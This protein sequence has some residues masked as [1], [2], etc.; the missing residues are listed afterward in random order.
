MAHVIED[1]NDLIL[2]VINMFPDFRMRLKL[3]KKTGKVM[4]G[5]DVQS[6]FDICWYTFS[7]IVAD[8]APPVDPDLRYEE[9]QGAILSCLC[10]GEFFV[11]HSS[12]QLY[13]DNPNC[14][15]ER[16][17]KNRRANYARKKAAE[18]ENQG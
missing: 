2:K 6:V 18:A 9:S 1:Y 12:R 11:R 15:A 17:R 8:V 5:A 4:F 16:N 13:C 10:C 7:R 14:Q 3:D